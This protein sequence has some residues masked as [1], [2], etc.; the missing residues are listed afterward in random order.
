MDLRPRAFSCVLV[1]ELLYTLI[2]HA[3]ACEQKVAVLDSGKPYH[4]P[5]ASIGFLFNYI[6]V[7][8]Y[9]FRLDRCLYEYTVVGRLCRGEVFARRTHHNAVH[10]VRRCDTVERE[11]NRG[12][13]WDFCE[14]PRELSQNLE[15]ARPETVPAGQPLPIPPQP[16]DYSLNGPAHYPE[17]PNQGYDP[18]PRDIAPAPRERG[19][20]YSPSQKFGDQTYPRENYGG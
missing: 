3:I 1:V 11:C 2:S 19:M 17:R 16:L 7:R 18:T 15:G 4:L 9:I 14:I 6:R 10:H 20:V 8:A 12:Q 13:G 5:E